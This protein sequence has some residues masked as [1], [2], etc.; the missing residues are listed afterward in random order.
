MVDTALAQQMANALAPALSYLTG[1]TAVV[2]AA[3]IKSIGEKIGVNTW[4]KAESIW[5]KIWPEVEKKPEIA[6]AIQEVAEKNN[7]PRAEALL[8]WQLEK[9]D[10][11]SETLAA[12][13]NILAQQKESRSNI[14]HAEQG[15][16][17]V[18]G[19]VQ[20]STITTSF[21]S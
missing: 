16:V 15:G 8:S 3:A 2:G 11:S 14:V 17:A 6:K 20:G 21:H 1:A 5:K 12:I 4:N 13:H 7:D 19:N 9:L 18:G 10:L